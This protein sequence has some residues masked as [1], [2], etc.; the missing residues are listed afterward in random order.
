MQNLQ[1]GYVL[2]AEENKDGTYTAV[3]KNITVGDEINYYTSLPLSPWKVSPS[4][5]E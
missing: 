1:R 2:C 5:I 4:D 3:K